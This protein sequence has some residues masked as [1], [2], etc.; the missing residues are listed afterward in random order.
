VTFPG[1]GSGTVTSEPGGITCNSSCS[2][3]FPAGTSITLTATPATGSVFG[4]WGQACPLAG[5]RTTCTL[6]INETTTVAV[7]FDIAPP[8]TTP[9]PPPPSPDCVVPAL[10]ALTLDAARARLRRGHC[11]L[12]AATR[13]AS[14]AALVGRVVWQQAA[15]GRHLPHLAKVALALGKPR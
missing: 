4:N 7:W 12:G 13:R 3:S 2:A 1:G 8:T 11:S 6:T 14:S 10:H 15:P 5:A 9:V